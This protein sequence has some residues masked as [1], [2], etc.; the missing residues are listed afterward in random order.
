MNLELCLV[1]YAAS[2]SA[3]DGWADCLR[4]ELRDQDVA[5]S[6]V[7]PGAITSPMFEKAQFSV[8]NEKGNLEQDLSYAEL[9]CE[10]EKLVPILKFLS[11]SPHYVALCALHAIR[12]SFPQTRY[13]VGLDSMIGCRVR[14]FIPDVLYDWMTLTA[15]SFLK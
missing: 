9:T 2:K 15:L 7:K 11:S 8:G 4:L 10:T 12:S 5:V 6:I 13:Y 3:I 1:R 14:P